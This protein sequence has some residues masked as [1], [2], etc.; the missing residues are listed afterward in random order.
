[1]ARPVPLRMTFMVRHIVIDTLSFRRALSAGVLVAAMVAASSLAAI[2]GPH[3]AL[4]A[5]DV[6][7]RIERRVEAASEFIV[8]VRPDRIDAVAARYGATL[9]K[10]IQGGGV[11]E[12]TG[13]Q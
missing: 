10:R 1:M 13:G 4:L 5:R 12:A 7:E 2:A 9:K 8:A 11:F 3:R 6:A